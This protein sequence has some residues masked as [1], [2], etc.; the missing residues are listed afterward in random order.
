MKNKKPIQRDKVPARVWDY[1]VEYF[2]ED[3]SDILTLLYQGKK[4]EE[5]TPSQFWNCFHVCT[6][7]DIWIAHKDNIF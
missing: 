6:Q 7:Q 1:L 5:L 4:L 3:K 2:K